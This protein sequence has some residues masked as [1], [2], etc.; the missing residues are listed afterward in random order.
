MKKELKDKIVLRD[1]KKVN[2]LNNII[3]LITGSVNGQ[4]YWND[5]IQ[6][7]LNK[8]QKYLCRKEYKG[9]D[10][11]YRYTIFL[12]WNG[13]ELV[14]KNSRGL[15]EDFCNDEVIKLFHSLFVRRT[16]FHKK[17]RTDGK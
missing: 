8:F 16:S 4:E 17:N 10:Y 12:D 6:K 14:L 1:Y 15:I 11:D 2:Q 13:L 3:T 7:D 5:K 9:N